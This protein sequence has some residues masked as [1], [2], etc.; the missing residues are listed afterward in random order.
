MMTQQK[1]ATLISSVTT[2]VLALMKLIVGLASG[3]VAVLASAIDSLLDVAI[4]LFNYFAISKSEKPADKNFNYGFGK[5][6]FIASLFEG[7]IILLSGLFIMYESI[8]K[9]INDNGI[10]DINSSIGVMLASVAITLSLVIFLNYVYKRSGNMVIKADT[11]HYKVDLMSNSAI[12][13]SLAIIYFSDWHIIDGILGICIAIYIIYSASKLIKDGIFMLLD[14]A[15]DSE[16]VEKIESILKSENISSYHCLR[17]RKSGNFIFV[18]VHLVFNKEI[19][20]Y[21]A[22]EISDRI[23]AK[24]EAIDKKQNWDIAIHLDPVDDS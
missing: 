16:T 24:I 17:T 18:D 13:V 12:L 15:V 4:S 7:I 9:I 14:R 1:T 11:L 6:E 22:H 3:S 8:N 10:K 5:I 2:T 19:L 21:D 20:L 23:E